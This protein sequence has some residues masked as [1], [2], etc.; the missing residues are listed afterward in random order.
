[1]GVDP[2][3]FAVFMVIA[4]A[5][6]LI[7]PS[8]GVGLYAAINVSGLTMEKITKDLVPWLFLLFAILMLFILFPQIA[9]VPVGMLFA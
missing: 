5:F 8:V 1:M 4:L 9:A 6:G 7:T 3:F 2:L